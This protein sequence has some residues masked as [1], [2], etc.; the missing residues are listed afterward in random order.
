MERSHELRA[1]PGRTRSDLSQHRPP[2]P[3][4][5]PP[6]SAAPDAHTSSAALLPP[7][8][9]PASPAWARAEAPSTQGSTPDPAQGAAS[10]GGPPGGAAPRHRA[11]RTADSQGRSRRHGEPRRVVTSWWAHRRVRAGPPQPALPPPHSPSAGARPRPHPRPPP[12][13]APPPCASPSCALAPA[14]PQVHQREKEGHDWKKG[15]RRPRAR[16]A[17]RARPP[18]AGGRREEQAR[19]RTAPRRLVLPREERQHYGGNTRGGNRLTAPPRGRGTAQLQTPT[20]LPAPPAVGDSRTTTIR[21]AGRTHPRPASP[22]FLAPAS[23]RLG[24]R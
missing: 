7:F 21:R 13:N 2:W 6:P 17:P 3:T 10:Q 20:P 12:A 11:A 24:P 9:A 22:P 15:R 19:S 4:A 23:P 1:S 8:L 14:P 16:P 5:A 18:T